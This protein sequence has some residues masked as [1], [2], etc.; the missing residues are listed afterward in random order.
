MGRCSFDEWRLAEGDLFVADRMATKS[1]V[2]ECLATCTF[3]VQRSYPQSPADLV[4]D[5]AIDHQ[6]MNSRAAS[7]AALAHLGGRT[8]RQ[9]L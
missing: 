8:S 3:A 7:I 6:T 4:G 9:A 2:A 1:L 5:R